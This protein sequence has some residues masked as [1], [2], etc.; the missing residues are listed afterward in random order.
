[1]FKSTIFQAALAFADGA[2]LEYLATTGNLRVD[3]W[4][5]A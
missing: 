2:I 3:P 1:M 4:A 5:N